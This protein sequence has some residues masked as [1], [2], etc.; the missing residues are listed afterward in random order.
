MYGAPSLTRP[1]IL[2]GDLLARQY[3]GSGNNG[4]LCLLALTFL[5]RALEP[6]HFLILKGNSDDHPNFVDDARSLFADLYGR[7]GGFLFARLAVLTS[8]RRGSAY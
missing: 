2:T 6:E 7:E 3:L 1:Y 5:L 8:V 4:V